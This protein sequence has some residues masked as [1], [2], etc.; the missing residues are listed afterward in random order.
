MIE[1]LDRALLESQHETL[2]LQIQ[3]MFQ[4]ILKFCSLEESLLA[5]A[6][7]AMSRYIYSYLS[8]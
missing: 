5:D 2:Y 7:A 3:Q 4:S 6:M 1:I 8:L